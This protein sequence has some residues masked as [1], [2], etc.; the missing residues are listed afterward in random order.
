MDVERSALSVVKLR[1]A[2]QTAQPL[3]G[4]IQVV[5]PGIDQG[6]GEPFLKR[7]QIEP[8]T[9]LGQALDLSGTPLYLHPSQHHQ[10]SAAIGSPID[11]ARTPQLQH[12]TPYRIQPQWPPRTFLRQQQPHWSPECLRQLPSQ[13]HQPPRR[14]QR[15]LQYRQRYQ[16][17][18]QS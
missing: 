13:H 7:H 5:A 18:P 14:H 16:Q 6:F 15:T 8:P 3:D 10:S 1:R 17:H 2:H 12:R 11:F 4:V 9:P